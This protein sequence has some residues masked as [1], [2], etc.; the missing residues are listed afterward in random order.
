MLV[1]DTDH[2]SLI[3]RPNNTESLRLRH[4]LEQCRFKKTELDPDQPEGEAQCTE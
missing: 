2:F 3:E 1:L 4:R